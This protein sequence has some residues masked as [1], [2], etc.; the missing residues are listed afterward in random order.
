MADTEKISG[1]DLHR[2][3]LGIMEDR[4]LLTVR[5]PSRQFRSLTVIT[6]IRRRKKK[7]DFQIDFPEELEPPAAD[8]DGLPFNFEFTDRNKIKHAFSSTSE[9]ISPTGIRLRYP[10]VI[11]RYQRRK[12]FR[13]DAPPNSRT[14]FELD[15]KRYELMIINISI[16]GTLAALLN[17]NQKLENSLLLRDTRFLERVQIQLPIND[18]PE[19]VIINRCRVKRLDKNPKTDRYEYALEFTDL[20]DDNE[21]RLTELI[22]EIQRKYLRRR[23]LMRS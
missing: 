16:G 2:L 6:D 9:S 22:Y 3:L 13:I 15:D 14:F 19:T 8:G 12:L 5:I 10:E 20:S 18:S 23:K 17:R 11:E 7:S 1:E 21:K 4:T